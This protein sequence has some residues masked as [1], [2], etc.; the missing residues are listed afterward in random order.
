[1]RDRICLVLE[2]KSQVQDF[3][4]VQMQ[5]IIRQAKFLQ[6]QRARA[7]PFATSETQQNQ[8]TALSPLLRTLS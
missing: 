2:L 6:W 8:L 1:M 3:D 4:V 5:D 7:N